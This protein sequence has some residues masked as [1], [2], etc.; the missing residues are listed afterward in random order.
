MS[1]RIEFKDDLHE[2][3]LCGPTNHLEIQ[4][5][6]RE[7]N[8]R[9]PLKA[10]C[11]LWELSADVVVAYESFPIVIETL[12]RMWRPEMV[13]RKSAVVAASGV[14]RAMLELYRAQGR[15]LPFEFG[16][17]DSRQEAIDWLRS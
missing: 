5:I 9:D 14:Q 6:Q 1:Y 7:L 17:F 12:R 13:G 4:E 11:D 3:Y 2:V 16:V 10:H 8:R 15:D